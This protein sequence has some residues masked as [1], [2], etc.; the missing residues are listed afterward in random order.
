MA[1]DPA[2]DADES[3]PAGDPAGV[4]SRPAR[5]LLLEVGVG[6]LLLVLL[7]V[8]VIQSFHV[9]SGSME[10]T[11]R[12]G[13]RV[14]VTKIGAGAVERGDVIVFDGTTTFAGGVS[15][16]SVP[17]GRLGRALSAGA[18]T[19]SIDLGEQDYLKRVVGVGG[20]TVSCTPDG[21]LVVNAEPAAEPWLAPGELPCETPFDVGVPPERLFVL[22]DNR[23]ESADS[24]S[25]LGD[26]GGGMVP[27]DDVVGH[28]VWRYWPLARTGGLGD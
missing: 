20:D 16:P 15:D 8:F 26:P 1:S 23:S 11:I 19:V 7:R 27:L 5:R 17:R 12:P 21:G 13:D 6:V 4:D 18:S 9:P 22:G 25:H 10:P 24:R 2:A 3:T 14:V 28:V